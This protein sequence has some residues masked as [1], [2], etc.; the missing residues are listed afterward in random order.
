M[1]IPYINI[2][3]LFFLLMY[4]CLVFSLNGV[5]RAQYQV[6]SWTT[7]N[8]LPQNTI[9]SIAQTRDG[10]LW[11]TT[12][13]G[14]VRYD[15]V[16]FKVFNKNNT[17]GITGNRLSALAED[18][19]GNLWIGAEGSKL[20]RY[21]NGTFHTYGT[22]DGLKQS[23][24]IWTFV[25]NPSG[26]LITF[27]D[28]GIV[29]WNG[30]K[31]VPQT[32]VAG[33]TK[34]S[35]ILWGRDSFWYS[36]NKIL[37]RYRNG[38]LSEYKLPLTGE[39]VFV[40]RLFED[41]RGRLWVGARRNDLFLLENERLTSYISSKGF[42]V[43]NF[44]PKIEDRYGNIWVITNNGAFIIS[45][46]GKITRLTS[47]QGLSENTIAA[48]YED[49][50]GSIWV[51]TFYRG[52]NRLNKQ[53]V[54]FFSKQ[55]GLS[56]DIVNPI[57]EDR[58]GNVWI[59]GKNLTKYK[60]G[61][62]TLVAEREKYSSGEVTAIH[63]DAH[64]RL[65]FGHW[66]GVYYLENGRFLNF[67]ETLGQP[68]ATAD[69]H[70]DRNGNLWIASN[71]GVYKY[72]DGVT[73]RIRTDEGLIN[74]DV[75]VIHESSDGSIWFGTYGGL[76]NL[77]DGKFTSFTQADGLS[78]NQIRSIYEDKDGI[79]WIGT[80][81]SG[82]TRLK[83][84]KFTRYTS[85]DGLFNDGVFQILED[86]RGNFWMSCNRGVY[87]VARS[88]LNDYADGKIKR[89]NSIAFGKADGLEETECNGGQQPAGIKTRDGKLWFPTQRG[90]AVI[91]PNSIEIN[92]HA[93]PVRI[94]SFSL[95]GV[96][97]STIGNVIEV[98]P[99]IE[100]L[101]I[102]YTGLS[103]IKPEQV[104]FKYK[105]NGLDS[106]W[107]D[108]DSRRTAYFSHL[109]PGEYTFT[110]I[111]A[112][113]D[114]VWNMEG[115]SIR[116]RV[117]PPFY[118]KWWF[119]VLTTVSVIGLALLFYNRRVRQLRKEKA[120]QELF[121][122]SLIESQERERGRIAAELHDGLSQSLVIIKN[123]A[124]LSLTAPDDAE[125]AFE[126]LEEIS[127]AASEAMLEAKEIIYDLRPIQLDRFGLRKAMMSMLKKVGEAHNIEFDI[128]IDA[129]DGLMA[130]E[131]ENSLY[132]ILQ[133]S[134]N[135]I[136]R[137]SEAY[138]ARVTIKHNKDGF[139]TMLIKDNGK[140]FNIGATSNNENHKGGF[141]LLGIVERAR[142]LKG[143]ADIQSTV[144]SGTSVKISLPVKERFSK[145]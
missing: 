37:Y 108:V 18:G 86:E 97:T 5:S 130:K 66:N 129:I 2:R 30:E 73:T 112:N 46:D 48:I 31:F 24:T 12:L 87:R 74:N 22:E 127:S 47:Q 75:K 72:K 123:R 14:L 51:G 90:V 32:P 85:N 134:I 52:L 141:G 36:I 8:G 42:L 144:G 3:K 82:L 138:E 4:G 124:V 11:L 91:D 63:Q 89:I 67:N 135:N 132:R 121:S 53:S 15:G 118:K 10:Y 96:I 27:T 45:V 111:A 76:S 17:K 137:H 57:Y 92:S 21:Y 68:A 23:K 62:F 69:I 126:Q 110:V 33:E 95:N 140:G 77:K 100:N 119:I 1:T 114:D 103:F 107:V 49:R 6:E 115:A 106:D 35:V 143:E 93:P 34:D 139:V 78:G 99:N 98:S 113:S 79:L 54:S 9:L 44:D 28:A 50:E 101:E 84:G 128:D 104:R 145:N 81:D 83:D 65:W 60:D 125:R 120:Q 80:Y 94:E 41:K 58:E 88:H 109:P 122:R 142:L 16:R 38:Q 102:T 116:V 70:E 133:E 64:G 13:D 26:E 117:V 105:M 55:D 7:D 29:R 71:R 61:R 39:D 19:K 59:G 25:L 43:N 56:A 40:T 20:I 136:V 131:A